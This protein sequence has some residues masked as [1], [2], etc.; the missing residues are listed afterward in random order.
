MLRTFNLGIGMVVVTAPQDLSQVTAELER[1]GEPY[2]RI[3]EV[4]DGGGKV[5][6]IS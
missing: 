6:F 4:V 2:Y 5:T 3:G 1:A